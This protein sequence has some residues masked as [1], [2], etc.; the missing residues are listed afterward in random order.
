MASTTAWSA[1]VAARI[2]HEM[3]KSTALQSL[4]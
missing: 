2:E 3:T 1:L 4:P